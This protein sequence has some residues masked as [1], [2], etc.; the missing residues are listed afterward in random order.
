[1]FCQKCGTEGIEGGFC[2]KCGTKLYAISQQETSQFQSMQYQQSPQNAF[3]RKISTGTTS[4][5][6]GIISLF[7]VLI[8][9]VGLG[10]GIAGVITGIVQ[11]TR[12]AKSKAVAGIILSAMGII[13]SAF[14]WMF[15]F[16]TIMDEFYF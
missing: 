8:P 14:M 16:V 10:T 6:L 3:V 1:M 5:V 13:L 15:G 9:I 11:R 2:P 12:G 7:G 4:L